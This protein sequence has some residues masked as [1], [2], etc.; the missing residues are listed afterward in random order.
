[1]QKLSQS[2]K[3]EFLRSRTIIFATFTFCMAAAISFLSTS[4]MTTS[5]AAD[6]SKF[7]PGNIISDAVM[8]NYNSMTKDEIQTFLDSKNKCNNT[9]YN[10][11]LSLTKAQPNIRWHWAG[12]P[13]NGHFVCLAEERFGDGEVIGSGMTA[14]EIIYDAAQVNKINPQV[15]LVL[16]QKESSLIT[17]K[18][19]NDYDYRKATGYGC[20]DTAACDSKYFG[21]KNQIYR[22][23]ELFRYTLDHG[24]TTFREGHNN[25]VGYHPNASCGGTQV[26]I[27]NRA[28]A[29]L[30]RY[31]PYQPNSAALN[32]GYGTGDVC[33]AYGNRNFYLYFMDWF[34]STQASVDGEQILIPDGTY[35]FVSVASSDRA[36]GISG[37]NV[38]LSALDK[39][40]DTQRWRIQRNSSTGAYTF[41][42]VATNK[43]LDLATSPAQ[44]GTNVQIWSTNAVCDQQ[45]KIYQTS[46]NYLTIETS[47]TGGMVLDTKNGSSSIGANVQTSLTSSSASQK[48]DIY[49]SPILEDGVYQVLSALDQNRGFDANVGSDMNGNNVSL[50]QQYQS[51]GHQIWQFQYHSTGNYYTIT[52][53]YTGKNLD[54]FGGVARNGTN[55]GIWNQNSSC[56]QKWKLFVTNDGAYDIRSVCSLS[57]ALDLN[58][59]ATDGINI[60]LWQAHGGQNQQW[61]IVPSAPAVAS[62]TYVITSRVSD[63]A[64]FDII[65][66]VNQDGANVA[67]W[68]K[69]GGANQQ[70]RID[71]NS[72]DG[73][74]TFYN[75]SNGRY[76]SI[77][78]QLA[79]DGANIQMQSSSDPCAI[80][81]YIYPESNGY[82]R[83]TTACR[84]RTAI[85]LNGGFANGNNIT[86]WQS[87]GG[88]HQQWRFTKPE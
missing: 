87:H 54:A 60:S 15:L 39:A 18:V 44:D 69:H 88:V 72:T 76:L 9:D 7:N 79:Y 45:W 40:D 31:T 22:A 30:Y 49:A 27:E 37:D 82:H 68:K 71:Y 12:E 13:Y 20:P 48:W 34:G 8:S 63:D 38:Q 47:C 67:I 55:I 43:R 64:S 84:T 78:N 6:A 74:Y 83:I 26:Y 19:P 33:S 41:T 28:T 70:W 57:Y 16:L 53:P 17:D 66:G 29:S 52:N 10:Y 59:A 61:Y 11:Y 2:F 4:N 5:S 24:S 42:N 85:D 32:A 23:A 56:A 21:F 14:A 62:D 73:T 46:D 80:K 75:A 51:K 25:Y 86:I 65:N 81:W 35:S 36:L 77:A 1:M 3:R 58:G 50:W